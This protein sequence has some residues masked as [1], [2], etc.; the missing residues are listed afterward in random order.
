M[1]YEVEIFGQS[2]SLRSDAEEEHVRRVA[3]LVDLKMREVASGSRSVSTLHIAVLAALD[4][5]SEYMHTE[6]RAERLAAEVEA[7][8]EAMAR[9]ITS[10]GS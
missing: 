8:A 6:A 1:A 10:A 7:R 4:I 9:R 2:Y 5:A 3:D